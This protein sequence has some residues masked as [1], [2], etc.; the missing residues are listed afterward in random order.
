MSATNEQQL[1]NWWAEGDT[2]VHADSHLTYLVDAHSPLYSKLRTSPLDTGPEQGYTCSMKLLNWPRKVSLLHP[3]RP[4]EKARTSS[5]SF[6]SPTD[7]ERVALRAPQYKG[8]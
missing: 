2:P 4:I 6:L 5:A 7:H 1:K 3:A 8:T